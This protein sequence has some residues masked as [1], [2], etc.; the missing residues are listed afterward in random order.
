MKASDYQIYLKNEEDY[1]R[2][3]IKKGILILLAFI[4][5]ACTLT[6]LSIAQTSGILTGAC[7][8]REN[9]AALPGY[10]AADSGKGYTMKKMGQVKDFNDIKSKCSDSI[11]LQITSPYC[12]SN[13]NPGQW[14]AVLYD[15]KGNSK[16]MGCA[17]SGCNYHACPV[18][19]T[20]PRTI[21]PHNRPQLQHR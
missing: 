19:Q 16:T 7:V 8:L 15:D 9:N 6:G 14:Q 13:T 11:Y 4:F 3:R 12:Q 5:M 20:P 1:M 21:Q 17:Q 18:V 10:N 2:N